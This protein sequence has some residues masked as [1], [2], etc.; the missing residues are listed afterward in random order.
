MNASTPR[1]AIVFESAAQGRR[2]ALKTT[3]D[4]NEATVAYH[5]ALNQLR[6]KGFVGD[7]LLRTQDQEPMELLR[8]PVMAGGR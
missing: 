2:T 7:V 5:A 3:N 8:Q 6:T 1:F 4:A